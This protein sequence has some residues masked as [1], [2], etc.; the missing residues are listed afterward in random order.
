MVSQ[1]RSAYL[2]VKKYCHVN[3]PKQI[4]S[5]KIGESTLTAESFRW[6]GASDSSY[7]SPC[8]FFLN[9]LFEG[10]N[11]RNCHLMVHFLDIRKPRRHK[12][13][14][15]LPNE[16]QLV[17]PSSFAFKDLLPE[18]HPKNTMS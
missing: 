17:M 8:V 5:V 13:K 1:L 14:P 15:T 4:H 18:S 6:V 11:E 2:N 10:E 3:W 7:T 12:F 9:I 16:T